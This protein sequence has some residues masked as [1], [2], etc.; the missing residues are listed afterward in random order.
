MCEWEY[1]SDGTWSKSWGKLTD[2]IKIGVI[3]RWEGALKMKSLRFYYV[4]YLLIDDFINNYL[5]KHLNSLS[6]VILK[7]VMVLFLLQT[8]TSWFIWYLALFMCFNI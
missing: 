7:Y 4:S 3:K 5:N 2:C 8:M 6:V 1:W